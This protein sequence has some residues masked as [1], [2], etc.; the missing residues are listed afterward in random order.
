MAS[1]WWGNALQALKPEL[2]AWVRRRPYI[3]LTA[4]DLLHDAWLSLRERFAKDRSAYPVAWFDE[5][6]P[7]EKEQEQFRQLVRVVAKRRLIDSFRASLRETLS[8]KPESEE[9]PTTIIEEDRLAARELLVHLLDGIAELPEDERELFIKQ[10]GL[11]PDSTEAGP[12]SGRDRIR[13]LRTRKRLWLLA[14]GKQ[15]H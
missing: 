5:G 12:M 2:S 3:A 6:P 11:G 10:V 8:K 14:Q 4:N 15:Q 7:S 1:E 13:L 9:Q